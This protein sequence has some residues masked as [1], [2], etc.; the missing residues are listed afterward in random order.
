MEK[1][2]VLRRDHQARRI[3]IECTHCRRGIMLGAVC[4]I[5][6]RVKGAIEPWKELRSPVTHREPRCVRPLLVS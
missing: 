6:R 2:T 4:S 1:L 5:R 3:E